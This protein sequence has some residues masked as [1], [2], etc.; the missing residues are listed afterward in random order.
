MLTY[1]EAK[2]VFKKHATAKTAEGE[3]AIPNEDLLPT[4]WD[5]KLNPMAATAQDLLGVDASGDGLI[6]WDEF[7]A[8]YRK[9]N[10]TITDPQRAIASF[11]VLDMD[12]SGVVTEEEMLTFTAAGSHVGLHRDD[13]Y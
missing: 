6:T 8:F 3:V 4:L 7:H 13:Y 12:G 10:D 2:R 11:R 5:A 9:L 1:Q